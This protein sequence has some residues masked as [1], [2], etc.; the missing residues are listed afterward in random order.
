MERMKGT[1]MT[2]NENIALIIEHIVNQGYD[3][4]DKFVE[5]VTVVLPMM[6]DEDIETIGQEMAEEQAQQAETQEAAAEAQPA[7]NA[8]VQQ[9]NTDINQTFK[10]EI[11]K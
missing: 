1:K 7:S 9:A 11:T 4:S 5:F 2:R 8:Q 10:S 3:S 6:T